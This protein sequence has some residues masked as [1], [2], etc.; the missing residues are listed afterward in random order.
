MHAL[1]LTQWQ[2][3]IQCTQKFIKWQGMDNFRAKFDGIM[4]LKAKS[5]DALIL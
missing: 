5:A 2:N 3:D 1:G 4:T